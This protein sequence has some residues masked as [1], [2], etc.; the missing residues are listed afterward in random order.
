MD[1]VLAVRFIVGGNVA[2]RRAARGI[3]VATLAAESGCSART[4]HGVVCGAVGVG[5]RKLT[6]I[7]RPLGCVLTTLFDEEDDLQV[8]PPPHASSS[9]WCVCSGATSS[10]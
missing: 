1:G 6:G 5:V 2:R 10:R 4:I 3:S 9:T 8:I 7:A